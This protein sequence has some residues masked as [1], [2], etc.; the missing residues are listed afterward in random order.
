MNELIFIKKCKIYNC[1]QHQNKTNK[2]KKKSKPF[3]NIKTTK[4]TTAKSETKKTT[5]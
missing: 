4:N 2:L 5:S 1:S 3:T